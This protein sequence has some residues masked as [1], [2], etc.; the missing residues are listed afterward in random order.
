MKLK[1][2][3]QDDLLLTFILKRQ[4]ANGLPVRLDLTRSIDI[5]CETDFVQ[6]KRGKASFLLFSED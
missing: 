5:Y 6:K 2:E 1:N 4:K 3:Y